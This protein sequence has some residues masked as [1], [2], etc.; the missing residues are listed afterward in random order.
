[1]A[2]ILWCVLIVKVMQPWSR[3]ARVQKANNDSAV[4]VRCVPTI[5]FSKSEAVHDVVI[6]L[7]INRHEFDLMV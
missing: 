1:M 2:L 7:Y 5:C 3:R 4:G 6:G